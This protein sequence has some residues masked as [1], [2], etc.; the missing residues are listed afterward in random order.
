MLF[1][2]GMKQT[3]IEV[4]KVEVEDFSPK[5]NVASLKV[6]Y[7][8]D[9]EMESM[10]KKVVMEKPEELVK[11]VVDEV[12]KR[13]KIELAET[14]D[15]LGSIFILHVVDEDRTEERLFNFFSKVCEK[16]R[17]LKRVRDHGEYMKVYNEIKVLKMAV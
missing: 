13:S 17:F 11:M 2:V 16:C 4:K 14:D 10:Y 6:S 1:G 3:R 5:E 8:R 7:L 15:P 9:G 12:K